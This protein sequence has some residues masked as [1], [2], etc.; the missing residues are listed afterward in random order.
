MADKPRML[1]GPGGELEFPFPEPL[2]G[3]PLHG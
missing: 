3:I 1:H 2:E